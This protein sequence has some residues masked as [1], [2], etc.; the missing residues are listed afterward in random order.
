LLAEPVLTGCV[1]AYDAV[2][3]LTV[4]EWDRDTGLEPGAECR[5]ADISW[6]R[7]LVGDGLDDLRRFGFDRSL[8]GQSSVQP[9]FR[10]NRLT[11]LRRA[12]RGR[13]GPETAV[14]EVSLA[15]PGELV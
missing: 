12:A 3:G 15:D 10:I 8:L 4:Y 5:N 1:D 2:D 9:E 14:G 6:Y 13:N 11:H 7:L